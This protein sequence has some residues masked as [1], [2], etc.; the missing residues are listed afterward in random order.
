MIIPAGHRLLV[1]PFAMEEVD[2]VL[3]NAKQSG[4]LDNF[5]IVK[6]DGQEKREAA[7]VDRATVI[8]VGATAFK[9]FGG[10]PWCK[11]GDEVFI[12]KYAGKVVE[13][14]HTKELFTL[15]NDEDI[16][17]LIKDSE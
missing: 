10:E 4:F 7:S 6:E 17:A 5:T 2:E 13:D 12:A 8:K 15:L 11:E 9:D 3:R 16:V 1:K 14:P